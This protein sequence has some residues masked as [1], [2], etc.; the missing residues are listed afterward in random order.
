VMH[1]GPAAPR[2]DN[3]SS[4]RFRSQRFTLVRSSLLRTRMRLESRVPKPKRVW[5]AAFAPHQAAP[6]P[7][8][9]EANSELRFRN[10]CDSSVDPFWIFCSV[11]ESMQSHRRGAA[12]DLQRIKLRWSTPLQH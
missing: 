4:I 3:L 5:I 6:T 11:A 7:G 12:E 1:F 10:R 9:F 2:H 8:A